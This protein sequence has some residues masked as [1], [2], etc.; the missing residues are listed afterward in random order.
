MKII[1]EIESHLKI[2]NLKEDDKEELNKLYIQLLSNRA[3]S[4]F[5]LD[6]YEESIKDCDKALVT[7][8][9]HQKCLFRRGICYTKL[10]E[11]VIKR[12]P[13]L[14]EIDMEM[15]QIEYY[16]KARKDMEYL[17]RL[18]TKNK[19]IYDKTQELIKVLVSLKLKHK[20]Q[21]QESGNKSENRTTE[22]KHERKPESKSEKKETKEEAKTDKKKE[23]PP[24]LPSGITKDLLDKVTNNAV[25][26]VTDMLV[27]G[28]ELPKT[29]SQFETHCQS[30]KKNIDKLYF[31]LKVNEYF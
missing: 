23:K 24:L 21:G 5:N 18:D 15:K 6:R 1:Q 17:Y 11:N 20:R 16:D 9:N 4:L 28:D 30:F 31:Y 7:D 12:Y 2:Q 14:K 10:A 22:S 3:L 13:D 26:N 29:S 8:Q 25:K 19:E 27:E